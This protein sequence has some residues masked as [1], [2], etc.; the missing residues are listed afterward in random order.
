MYS[1]YSSVRASSLII[2]HALGMFDGRRR[3]ARDAE[4]LSDTRLDYEALM[5]SDFWRLAQ[6]PL[7]LSSSSSYSSTGDQ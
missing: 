6:R 7:S 4:W 5:I 2:H 3:V 1:A